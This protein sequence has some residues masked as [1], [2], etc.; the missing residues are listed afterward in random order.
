MMRPSALR[1]VTGLALLLAVSPLAAEP[2]AA[3]EPAEPAA[4]ASRPNAPQPG[5]S[6]PEATKPDAAKA[7]PDA[8]P[9][10]APGEST[11]RAIVRREALA[12]GMPPEVAE[13]VA[14]VES[15]FNTRA[16]GGVGEIG[17]MQVLPST[18]RMMGFSEP[19]P[20]L[21]E[22]ETNARYGVRYLGEAWRMTGSDICAT[23]MKYRAGHGET[24]Y[25]RKSVAYCVRVRALLAAR[26][27]KVTGVVPVATFGDADGVVRAG[28][29]GRSTIGRRLPNGRMRVVFNWRPT[30]ARRHALDKAGSASLRIT[31]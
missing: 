23:V 24:R 31:D 2:K 17:L 30:D 7:E 12:D 18:A 19:L 28:R 1:L 6:E 4:D 27:F 11:L 10:P 15:G 5:A 14:E 22:P 26:G 8:A 25:S 16:V 29:G 9:A 3:P 21:F 20:K 13:A